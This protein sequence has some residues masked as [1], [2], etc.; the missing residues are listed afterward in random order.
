MSLG[1]RVAGD[2]IQNVIEKCTK[3]PCESRKTFVT[4][5]PQQTSATIAIY[6][7]ENT[8]VRE[9]TYLGHFMITGIPPLR[10]GR[11]SVQVTFSRD[12]SGLLKV[13]AECPKYP[14]VKGEMHL[15]PSEKVT[16][17][18]IEEGQGRSKYF[19]ENI[20]GVSK[21]DGVQ[22]YDQWLN[23]AGA[24]YDLGKD[25]A[26]L[27]FTVLIGKFHTSRNFTEAAFKCVQI[28]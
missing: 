10:A 13:T 24:K 22:S 17:F 8:N 16:N 20:A 23:P 6:E 26:F 12:V 15:N 25:G 1:I 5:I 21:V 14:H 9:S 11:V 3:I 27:D 18:I 28:S 4:S 7:G 19:N 2:K